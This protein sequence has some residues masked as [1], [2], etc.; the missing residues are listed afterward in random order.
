MII[1]ALKDNNIALAQKVAILEFEIHSLREAR[2]E[3]A[4]S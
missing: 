3:A 1:S 4:R 2:E